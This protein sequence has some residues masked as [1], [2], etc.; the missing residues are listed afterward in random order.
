MPH[1]LLTLLSQTMA[2]SPAGNLLRGYTG[3]AYNQTVTASGGVAPYSYAVTSG[4]LPNGLS[5]NSGTGAITGTPTVVN[6]FSFTITATDNVSQKVSATCVITVPNYTNKV[7]GLLGASL[8][9]YWTL[10][11]SVGSTA[12]DATGHGY[13]GA[14][15]A[16]TFGQTGI[17]DGGTS[18]KFDGST[19]FVNLYSSALSTAFPR[20]EGTLI[21]WLQVRANSVWS[22]ATN[23][24]PCEFAIDGSNW[25]YLQK[26]TTAN[27]L[28]F[29][30]QG[31]GTSKTQ[32]GTIT[33]NTNW[34]SLI[35]SW[36]V[37]NNTT[38]LYYDGA[39]LGTPQTGIVALSNNGFLNQYMAIGCFNI[40]PSQVWDGQ[41]AHVAI[42]T[43][44]VTP[45]EAAALAVVP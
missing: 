10:G 19:S 28:Q 18:A 41:L 21:A 8:L 14:A 6:T 45:T 26:S 40:T 17:G 36:S 37:S 1:H 44:P 43:R 29:I 20:A 27:Q 38:H 9:G 30:E 5:L 15:T 13:T 31:A 24:N 4:A 25:V 39:E 42:V 33:A 23:R 7:L 34:H 11:D 16:V 32:Q 2:L 35:G 22:D 12:A 3:L